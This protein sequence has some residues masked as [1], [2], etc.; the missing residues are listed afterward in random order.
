MQGTEARQ[1]KAPSQVN[2]RHLNKAVQGI[3]A[4]DFKALRQGTARHLGKSE[5]GT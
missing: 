4:S 1:C 3:Y 5:Q 2:A